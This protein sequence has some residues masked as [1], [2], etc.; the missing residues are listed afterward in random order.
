MGQQP[1]I[2]TFTT[3]PIDTPIQTTE[4]DFRKTDITNELTG[5]SLIKKREGDL[6]PIDNAD[7]VFDVFDE[8]KDRI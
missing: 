3:I 8:F 4:F 7:D 6:K 1:V 5:E 2:F